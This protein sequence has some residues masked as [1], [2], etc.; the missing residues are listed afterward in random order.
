MAK[1]LIVEDEVIVAW[2]IKETL[3]KLGSYSSR[4]GNFWSGSHSIGGRRAARFGT[5]GYPVR[6]RNGRDYRWR[7]DLSSPQNPRRLPHRS[8]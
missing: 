7:R 1:I 4:S 8:R 6:W 2:D 5:D 3:E